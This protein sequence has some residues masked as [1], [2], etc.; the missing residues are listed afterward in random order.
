[1][2]DEFI[3][4]QLIF[5]VFVWVTRTTC[6]HFKSFVAGFV[7]LFERAKPARQDV[8]EKLREL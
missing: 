8:R 4:I 2:C 5:V 7:F 3:Y 1:M 6:A